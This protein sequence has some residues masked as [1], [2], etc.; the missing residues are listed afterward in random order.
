MFPHLGWLELV[1][2]G[3]ASN[4]IVGCAFANAGIKPS[5]TLSYNYFPTDDICCADAALSLE[6]PS[7]TP[8]EC[9]RVSSSRPFSV[10]VV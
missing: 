4:S 7:L 5:T 9:A 10:G 3:G 1:G 2:V 8:S 6:A